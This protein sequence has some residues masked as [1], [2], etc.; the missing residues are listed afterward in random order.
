MALRVVNK[1]VRGCIIC[2]NPRV[3]KIVDPMIFGCEMT[4]KD[5]ITNL[6]NQDIIIEEDMLRDHISH[7]FTVDDDADDG[8]LEDDIGDMTNLKVV[9]DAIRKII[10]IE[11][12]FVRSG[13]EKTKEFMALQKEKREYLSLKAKL[14]GELPDEVNIRV[15]PE[16]IKRVPITDECVTQEYLPDKT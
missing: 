3:Y 5:I 9:E 16:W 7:I 15:L 6:S 13:D 2:Q 1:N 8:F 11:N 10:I 4:I 12:D 14:E